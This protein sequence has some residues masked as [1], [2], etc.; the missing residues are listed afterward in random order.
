MPRILRL[1]PLAPVPQNVVYSAAIAT[2]EAGLRLEDPGRSLLGGLHLRGMAD[3]S[4]AVVVLVA[5]VGGYLGR[6]GPTFTTSSRRRS[7]ML[8]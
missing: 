2:P 7:L 6:S 4:P 5:E 1:I 3:D 8:R